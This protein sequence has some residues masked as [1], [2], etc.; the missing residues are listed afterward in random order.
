MKTRVVALSLTLLASVFI[1]AE[2]PDWENELVVGR[3]K[4]PVHATL[5]PF[6]TEQQALKSGRAESP[7]RKSL[8]GP[9]KFHWVNHPDKRPMDFYKPSVNVANWAEIEVPSNWEMKG[10]GTP[11]YT[12][13]RYPHK[14]DPPRVMGDPPAEFTASKERNPVGSYRRTFAIPGDWKGRETFV[15]FDGVS[16]AFYLWING[17][18]V[19][20]SED[21]R[22]PAEFNIT[23]FLKAGE[24]TIA[25]QVYRWSDGSYLE[26]QD[27][28]RMSGI[29]R[30]VYLWSAPTVHMRDY[31]VRTRLDDQY[32]NA[33]LEATV[34]VVAYR[35]ERVEHFVEATLLDSHGRKSIAATKALVPAPG[36]VQVAVNISNPLKWSAEQPN[37]YTLLL[38]LRDARGKIVEVYRQRVGFRRVEIKGG[39]LLVNGQPIYIKGVNRH[40]HDPVTGQHVTTKGMVQDILLMKQNNINTVR[41]SHYP[42]V[43]EWYELCDEYGLYVIDEANVES[44]GMDYGKESLAKAP[45]WE[46]AHMTRTI[47][48]VERDKNHASVIIW[49]L[50]NEAGNGV[51]FEKTYAW[52]KQRDPSRPVQYEQAGQG[53]NTDI[54]CPMYARIGQMVEYAKK[55]PSKPLIQC[56]YA[57]AMG[58]SVGNLQDY[59]DAIEA[60]P[61]LQGA[62]IWDW[63]NQSISRPTPK[64]D[65]PSYWKKSWYWAFGGDFG[66]R[67]TDQNFCCNGVICADR[68]PQPTLFEVKKVYQNIKV[69]PV[70]LAAGR[71]RIQNKYFFTSLIEFEATWELA[72]EGRI[73][74]KGRIGRLD[75][76]PRAEKEITLPGWKSE[77]LAGRDVLVKVS[78]SVADKKSWAEEGHVV[79]WDQLPLNREL[80]LPAA[81]KNA[82]SSKLAVS[83]SPEAL[84]VSGRDFA[85]RI[86]RTSGVIEGYRLDGKELIASPLV[87]NFWRAP[88]DNDRGNNMAKWAGVWKGAGPGR[89]VTQLQVDAQNPAAVRVTANMK[90][91][92][93]ESTGACTYTIHPSGVI[94]IHSS[95]DAKGDKLPV[96]PRIGLMMEMPGSF[97]RVEWHGRGPHENYWDRN[98]GA[99]IGRYR[100]RVDEL[101]FDY[102]EPGENG[103]RTDIRWATFANSKGTG[104]RVRGFPLFEMNAWPYRQ[105]DLEGPA[106]PYEMPARDTVTVCLDYRQMGVGGDDSWGA[107][108]H[109]EYSLPANRKYEYQLRLEPMK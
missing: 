90:F 63:V 6:E 54:Y 103:H 95:I 101:P 83:E 28:W 81:I 71:V 46:L 57:H 78:F 65:K 53:A 1:R 48:V 77:P 43:P 80:P 58:N 76:A 11:I 51:N 31:E 36:K 60:Y 2:A 69:H 7:F 8:N 44:H 21:S 94:D 104:F 56:E 34:D 47:A 105:G 10:Y 88:T 3:N 27:F 5:M 40:E 86:G 87:P 109:P 25:A 74:R 84:T 26:D 37:L 13:I 108:T 61:A 14:K 97:D 50:G 19:G 89:T 79:A 30:E 106:H 99:A 17:E 52:V 23:R 59:W 24:N 12:N 70:D 18:M 22:T 29:F 100:A 67:P 55:N 33:Q 72:E 98:T 20:Y 35:N 107:R 38:T 49:S 41:T 15:C 42:N 32:R 66:D 96:I 75:V 62:C 9:W 92:A 68:T 93:G 16:S 73:L 64:L 45:S 4:E 102:V 85:V 39:Q 82:G 91:P